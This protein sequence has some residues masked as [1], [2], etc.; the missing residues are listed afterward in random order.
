M[1]IVFDAAAEVEGM[2]LNTALL[3]GPDNLKSLVAILLQ[4]RQNKAGVTADIREMF[5]QIKVFFM[6]K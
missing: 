2:S 6:A 5:S 1:R 3:K 4:F